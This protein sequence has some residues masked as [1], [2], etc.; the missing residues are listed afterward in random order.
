MLNVT[1]TSAISK[2]V[3][4]HTEMPR[5]FSN[6]EYTDIHFVYGFCNGNARA[7]VRKINADLATEEYRIARCLQIF[8]PNYD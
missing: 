3:E 8:T 1:S 7:A 4:F 2:F 5:L 6:E